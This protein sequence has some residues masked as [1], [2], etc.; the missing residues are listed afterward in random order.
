MLIQNIKKG[1]FFLGILF[2]AACSMTST[3]EQNIKITAGDEEIQV[4]AYEESSVLT[5]DDIEINNQ[6]LVS[7]M[8]FE[9]IPYVPLSETI[10]LEISNSDVKELVIDDYILNK[11][12]TFKFSNELVETITLPLENGKAMFPLQENIAALL[13]S[14]TADYLPGNTLRY[15]VVRSNTESAN[16]LFAFMVRTDATVGEKDN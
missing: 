8:G 4:I 5:T 7:G 16:P 2:L 13:S 1:F 15:F 14:N 3:E 12:G 11:N 9:E 6:N 10:L